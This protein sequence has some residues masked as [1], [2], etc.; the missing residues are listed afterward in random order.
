[1][2]IRIGDVPVPVRYFREASSIS[3]KRSCV[4]GFSALYYLAQYLLQQAGLATFELLTPKK[5][6]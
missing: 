1:M 6:A 5:S 3:F 4:Y 2:K